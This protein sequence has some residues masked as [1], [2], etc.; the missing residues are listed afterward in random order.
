MS[1]V[2]IQSAKGTEVKMTIPVA[3][4]YTNYIDTGAYTTTVTPFNPYYTVATAAHNTSFS[5]YGNADTL[6][7]A[8]QPIPGINDLRVTIVDLSSVRPGW[9]S[10]YL[11]QYENKGTTTIPAC[12]VGFVLPSKLSYTSAQPAYAAVS[13]DTLKWDVGT[14]TP[15]SSGSITL[16]CM[17][18]N[19]P[20]VNH[21]DTIKTLA[22]IAPALGDNIPLDNS[23]ELRQRVF[24]SY[25]PNAKSESHAGSISTSK[26]ASGEYLQY[27]IM[28]QNTGND[29]A[30]NITIRDTLSALLD[31]NTLE[32]VTAS[33]NYQLN[34]N[35]GRCVWA[36][37]NIKLV[38]SLHNEPMSHGYLVYRIKPKATV[39][40]G[41][42]I[43]NTAGIYF[44]NN[45]PVFTNTAKT[46]VVSDALPLK[47][48]SFTATKAGK[49]N[50]L[51]W[52]TANEVAVDRF[53]IQRS[54]NGLEYMTIGTVPAQSNYSFTDRTPP[55]A[56]NYY[57]L[58]MVDKDGRFTYSP[59][60]SVNNSGS[61]VVSIYPNPVKDKLAVAIESREQSLQVQV[62]APNGKMLLTTKWKVGEGNT[63]RAINTSLLSQGTY[64]LRVTSAE[65]GQVVL[66]FE[67]L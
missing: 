54:I 51:L 23:F 42:S 4:L 33:H 59:V 25:D 13:G 57:R 31:W 5:T 46:Y 28:F 37:N 12:S 16:T 2:H 27:T 66:K 40:V 10:R 38:D 67:K 58:M 22:Y 63:N 15:H 11:I 52:S 35:D 49:T 60:R 41:D 26:V 44:D 14:L 65:G 48:L 53:A 47:L 43:S 30:Y 62:V 32:M 1:N 6:N 64:F 55:A 7:I 17:V 21:G 61:L 56:V 36:F 19:P 8:V 39:Q 9:T 20:V 18:Q 24:N 29:T 50:L 3:G 34:V 45:L